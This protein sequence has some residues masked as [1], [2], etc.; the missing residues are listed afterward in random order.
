MEDSLVAFIPAV[1]S[2]LR[3]SVG[4]KVHANGQL[5]SDGMSVR[6]FTPLEFERLQGFPDG[7]TAGQSDTQR[8]KQMGNAVAVP[9]A[10]WIGKQLAK[11]GP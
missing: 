7:W 5:I 11:A 9:V 2:T 10:E 6:L 4:V 8:Y 1:A 3:A